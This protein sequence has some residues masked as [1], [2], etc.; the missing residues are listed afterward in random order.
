MLGG[1]NYLTLSASIIG[2]T[3][4]IFNAKG[5][6]IGQLLTIVFSILYGIISYSYQYFGEMVTYLG[7]TMPMAAIALF[8]WLKNPHIESKAEVRVE[9]VNKKEV[10]N[11][12]LLTIL[13]TVIFYF[14]L[15]EMN[16]SNL[17]PST[18]SVSTSFFAAC[19]TY[20]R[21]PFFALAYAMNDLVLIILWILASFNDSTYISVVICFIVFLVN[22]L[23]GFINWKNMQKKQMD[24]T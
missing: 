19:L 2:T 12:V 23:Y 20:K 7:M 17:L 14:I 18:L 3:F 24:E 6:P 22:D 5:N 1:E 8:S 10:T 4:L 21:S 16:T 11:I 13:I 15:R 9:K